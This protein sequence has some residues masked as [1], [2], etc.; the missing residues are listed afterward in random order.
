MNKETE[1]QSFLAVEQGLNDELEKI[2]LP[3]LELH[4]QVLQQTWQAFDRLVHQAV[5]KNGV[6]R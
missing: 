2:E 1:L 6:W 4:Q 5:M 3:W